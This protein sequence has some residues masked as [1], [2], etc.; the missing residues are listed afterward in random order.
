MWKSVFHIFLRWILR[1]KMAEWSILVIPKTR[2][3]CEGDRVCALESW[4]WSPYRRDINWPNCLKEISKTV[5]R[6]RI[7]WNIAYYWKPLSTVKKLWVTLVVLAWLGKDHNS[8]AKKFRNRIDKS[9]VYQEHQRTSKYDLRCGSW[10]M[11]LFKRPNSFE[12]Y[13]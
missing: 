1:E 9:C 12:Y 6:K 2:L 11:L 13:I 8:N 7:Y 10:P 4:R 3:L 5:A